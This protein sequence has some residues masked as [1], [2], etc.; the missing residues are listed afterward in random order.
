MNCVI[1]HE[2]ITIYNKKTL[3]CGHCYHFQ[4]I[5]DWIES[6]HNHFQ[7][8]CPICRKIH[9]TKFIAKN[10]NQIVINND[11]NLLLFKFLLF[12]Y[13]FLFFLINIHFTHNSQNDNLHF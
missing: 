9:I 4:C 11:N 13:L 2:Q 3:N 6:S 7:Y 8:S 12:G 1:C 10:D 5:K